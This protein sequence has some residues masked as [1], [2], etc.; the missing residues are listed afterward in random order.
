MTEATPRVTR[1]EEFTLDEISFVT[2]PAQTPALGAIIKGDFSDVSDAQLLDDDYWKSLEGEF[3][4]NGDLAQLSSSVENDHEHAIR[5]TRDERSGKIYVWVQHASSS[6]DSHGHEHQIVIDENGG[7]RLTENVGHTH[8]IDQSKFSTLLAQIA[9]QGTEKASPDA[10]QEAGV[11]SQTVGEKETSM[12]DENKAELEKAAKET[13]ALKAQVQELS[14]LAKMSDAEKNFMEGLDK[15]KKAEFMAMTSADRKRMMGK[16]KK[17]ADEAKEV[18]YKSLDGQ[19]FTKAD[20]TRLV[21]MAKRSDETR[22][23]LA[24]EKAARENDRLEKSVNEELQYLPGDVPTRTALLKAAEGIADEALRKGAIDA[25]KAHNAKLAPAFETV[26][27]SFGLSHD[28]IAKKADA[29]AALDK[30][31]QEIMKADSSTFEDAF[32]KACD[33]NPSLANTAIAG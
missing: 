12:T 5:M 28:E 20:D 24:L 27:G 22:K 7:Y 3:E 9:L 19:E 11:T 16:T 10:Q 31:A 23:E 29:E 15:E 33:Q 14:T 18:V 25:L 21:D 26:G 6:E 32:A 4:K 30:K 1:M 13:E 17:A 8:E 2:K